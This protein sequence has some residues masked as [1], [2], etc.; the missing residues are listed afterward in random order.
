MVNATQPVPGDEAAR[1]DALRALGIWH[2]PDDPAFT[3][4]VETAA[5]MLSCPISLV[6]LIGERAQ[7][8]KARVGLQI[9]GTPRENAF[10][11]HTI[12]QDDMMVV[13]DAR[14][15]P[16][17][18]DNPLV[19]GAPG[20][21]FYAGCPVHA[22][23]GH[24]I[25]TLCVIDTVPRRAAEVPLHRL[26]RLAT[27]VEGL[28]RAYRAS[29][30]AERQRA[31]ADRRERLLRQ[32]ET[33]AEIG[34]WRVDVAEGKLTWSEQV[35]AIHDLPVGDPPGLAEA[36]A[37]YPGA[38]ADK[39]TEAISSALETGEP[40]FIEATLRTARGR[41]RRVRFIGEVTGAPPQAGAGPEAETREISGVIQD[42]TEQH[43]AERR[44]WESAHVDALSGLANRARF[45]MRLAEDLAAAARSGRALA[46]I[47]IDLDGFKQT[48]DTFGHQAGDEVIRVVSSRLR[49]WTAD[50][51]LCSRIGGDEFAILMTV[52]ADDAALDRRAEDLL[53]A[54]RVPI[55][56]SGATLHVGA[57]VGVA[58]APEDA[59]TPEDL[60]RCADM[61]L[62]RA[63]R[64]GR[65]MVRGYSAEV[66]T[67]FDSRRAAVDLVRTAVR[68][69]V[70]EPHYQPI[71]HLD[72]GRIAG[73]EA[74][75]RIRTD[76]GWLG[77]DVFGAAFQD[78][79]CVRLLDET[80]FRL[81]TQD[82]GAWRSR[83]LDPGIVSLNVSAARL[84]APGFVEDVLQRLRALG[85]PGGAMRFEIRE[86]VLLS[87]EPGRIERVFKALGA[88]GVTILHD[89]FGSGL[90]SLTRLRD[91]RIEGVKI[92]RDY[93]VGIADNPEGQVIVKAI[94]DLAHSMGL[95]MVAEG[96]EA[97]ADLAFLK[98]IACRKAQ[99]FL[100]D[101]ALPAEAFARRLAAPDARAAGDGG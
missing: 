74:L 11:R 36:I 40:F 6:S 96:V 70:L 7:W 87:D 101:P 49:D 98:K 71:V 10:C 55:V 45:N 1:L 91:L 39:V 73:A 47:L 83:G 90:A 31:A 34:A 77:P 20:I 17:F 2:T 89:D 9:D 54:I 30:T 42:V 80:M 59:G 95:R 32:I 5:D 27:V 81:V 72:S 64:S 12:L 33:M 3:A 18:R 38:E 4:I 53:R 41:D 66:G 29:A 65:G 58:R 100:F 94:V 23:G 24:A 93:I 92:G 15:D 85:I 22:D 79:D 56:F 48:N 63:K 97:P 60:L 51:G 99:G 67:V 19:T 57:S 69:G 82:V 14:T 76:D 26:R 84:Q 37:Y 25:G 50:E 35:F 16:R 46:L 52:E 88:A 61:A 62:Y 75:A 43:E 13:E 68:T 8:F 86:D 44:L 21:R 78:P 28:L